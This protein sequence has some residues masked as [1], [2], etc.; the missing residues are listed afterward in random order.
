[1][2]FAS[3]KN[4]VNFVRCAGALMGYLFQVARFFGCVLFECVIFF[5]H[6]GNWYFLG[7]GFSL[8]PIGTGRGMFF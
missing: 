7:V 8:L 2:I 6:D 3:H 1:M 5:T 4:S